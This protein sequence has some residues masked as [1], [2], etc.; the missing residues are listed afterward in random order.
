MQGGRTSEHSGTEVSRIV[1]VV[2]Q[3]HHL[4]SIHLRR[5]NVVTADS[6]ILGLWGKH[7]NDG[8]H[9]LKILLKVFLQKPMIPPG[10][11]DCTDKKGS[12]TQFGG[13]KNESRLNINS[14]SVKDLQLNRT[15]GWLP[16]RDWQLS[17]KV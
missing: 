12:Q 3:V 9:Y 14:P 16:I 4:D 17:N 13:P 11:R 8:L 6:L 2:V 5:S 1:S 15:R 7:I 10:T